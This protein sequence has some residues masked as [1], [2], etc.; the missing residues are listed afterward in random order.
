[1]CRMAC[2]WRRLL[3]WIRVIF[4]IRVRLRLPF[5]KILILSYHAPFVRLHL[6]SCLLHV[7]VLWGPWIGQW[8]FQ[9]R[10]R[11]FCG[12]TN[13][14]T[15]PQ[16]YS[17]GPGL[18]FQF[19]SRRVSHVFD[20]LFKHFSQ[21]FLSLPS[22]RSNFSSALCLSPFLFVRVNLCPFGNVYSPCSALCPLP[23]LVWCDDASWQKYW[24]CRRTSVKSHHWSMVCL[25]PS[26]VSRL[27]A[28]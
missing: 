20:L 7:F 6:S 8:L 19:I 3:Q 18:Q 12:V 22:S 16:H 17:S 10:L 2:L 14:P 27:T 5:A 4:I 28:E 26:L 24:F 15:R 11:S 21:L 1:M 13:Y 23:L 25:S 9:W